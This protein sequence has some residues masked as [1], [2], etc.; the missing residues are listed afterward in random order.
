[1]Y[2]F[3]DCHGPVH[4]EPA[5]ESAAVDSDMR[6]LW[7]ERLPTLLEVYGPWNITMQMR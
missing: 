6:N 5:G 2:R 1:M 4:R 3:K 7:L